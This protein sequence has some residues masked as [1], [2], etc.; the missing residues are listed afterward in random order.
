MLSVCRLSMAF[1]DMAFEPGAECRHFVQVPQGATWCECT[2]TA[3]KHATPQKFSIQ[4]LQL[5]PH[6]RPQR[7]PKALQLTSEAVVSFVLPMTGGEPCEIA[8][9][10]FWMADSATKLSVDLCFGG[11]VAQS[12]QVALMGSD[13]VYPLMVWHP[14]WRFLG[15]AGGTAMIRQISSLSYFE[16]FIGSTTL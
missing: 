9:T 3:G 6:K 7:S 15:W 13:S 11:I 10:Q 2:V 14:L 5:L 8:I 1:K 16:M 4:F 12:K